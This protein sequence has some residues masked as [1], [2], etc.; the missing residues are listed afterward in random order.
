MKDHL[1][2]IYRVFLRAGTLQLEFNGEEI[3]F[4]DR[5]FLS[6]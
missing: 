1:R 3:L 6:L 2:S 4:E 5:K